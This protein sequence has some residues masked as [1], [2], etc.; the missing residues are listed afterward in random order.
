MS[1]MRRPKSHQRMDRHHVRPSP[2]R[3]NPRRALNSP[4]E[5][6]ASQG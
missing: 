5:S 1:R 2:A 3:L 4:A 6:V